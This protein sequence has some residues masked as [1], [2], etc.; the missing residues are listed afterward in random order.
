MHDVFTAHVQYDD[1]KG[2]VAAD[3]SDILSL[4]T[5]LVKLGKAQEGERVVGFRFGINEN[6]GREVESH[7]FVFYLA[8]VTAE[9]TTLREVRAVE[10]NMTTAKLLSFFKR[11]DLV[12]TDQRF[13]LN[14]VNVGLGTG[15]TAALRPFGAAWVAAQGKKGIRR[16]AAQR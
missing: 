10:V 1:F 6:A 16:A 3:R 13:N 12:A 14:G 15:R 2:P 11:F 5:H 4:S 8:R 7:G 9:D